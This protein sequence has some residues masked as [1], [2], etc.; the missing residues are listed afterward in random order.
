M[1]EY[2]Q[3]MGPGGYELFRLHDDSLCVEAIQPRAQPNLPQ[4]FFITELAIAFNLART[5]TRTDIRPLKVTI[6]E[7]VEPNT[8][9]EHFFGVC[10]EVGD[11][12]S[13]VFSRE[14]AE[15][16]FVTAN[17]SMWLMLESSLDTRKF[18]FFELTTT[19]ERVRRE[20]LELIPAGHSVV[21]EVAQRLNMSRRTL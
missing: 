21:D 14:D 19:Y 11:E 15:R 13:I 17:H 7:L 2:K 3:L 1:I 10:P 18:E 9:Y 8:P 20:L 6:R 16:R 5:A 4:S 12:N